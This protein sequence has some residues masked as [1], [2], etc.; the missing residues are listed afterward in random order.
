MTDDVAGIVDTTAS[1]ASAWFIDADTRDNVI[2]P[3]RDKKDENL[4]SPQ[5]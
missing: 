4:V 3:E 1:S 5:G 2:A